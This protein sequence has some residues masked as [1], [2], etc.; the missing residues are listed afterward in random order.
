MAYFPSK[1]CILADARYGEEMSGILN[2][3]QTASGTALSYRAASE[4]EHAVHCSAS[5]I[6]A[7]G[8]GSVAQQVK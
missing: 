3:V 6:L 1:K 4:I 7:T 2:E 5:W 8:L